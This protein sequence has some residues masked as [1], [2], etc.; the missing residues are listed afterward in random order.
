M[1]SSNTSHHRAYF[2]GDRSVCSDHHR[3]VRD[4]VYWALPAGAVRF[5]GRRDALGGAGGRLRLRDGDG[6]LPAVQFES[7]GSSPPLIK[8]GHPGVYRPSAAGAVVPAPAAS[9]VAMRS[10]ITE[11]S[12]FALSSIRCFPGSSIWRPNIERAP[13]IR[14]CLKYDTAPQSGDSDPASRL[15]APSNR[16]PIASSA[17]SRSNVS[18]LLKLTSESFDISPN[19]STE[20]LR[21]PSAPS[22]PVNR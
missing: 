4:L 3:L 21:Y 16:A 20:S 7:V 19:S 8:R 6:P 14:P 17:T 10:F 9:T 1:A 18:N 15:T 5:R 22:F 2:P 13:V 11:A 12:A